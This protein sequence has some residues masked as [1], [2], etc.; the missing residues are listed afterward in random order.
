MADDPDLTTPPPK[1]LRNQ[2]QK[3]KAFN[4]VQERK[5]SLP[6]GHLFIDIDKKTRSQGS[7]DVLI[8]I[9]RE[10]ERSTSAK[11]GSSKAP[12]V[13]TFLSR[14]GSRGLEILDTLGSG[15]T[16]L[17]NHRG[18]VSSASRWNKVSELAF[19]VANTIVMGSN[20]MQ[21]LSQENIQIIE[22]EMLHS[23]RVQLLV[24]RDTKELLSIAAADKREEFEVFLRD[25][26]RFG[27][28]CKGVEWHSLDRF[29]VSYPKYGI[30]R[31]EAEIIMQELVNL[32]RHTSELYHESESLDKLEQFCWR[33]LEEVQSSYH[34]RKGESLMI[35][36]NEL[37]QQRKLV[38]NLKKKSLWSKS[39]DEVVEKL[40]E[41]V[42]FIR[43]EIAEAFENVTRSTTN[44]KESNKEPERLGI[45]GL[46]L[47]YANLITQI[48]CIATH[49][50]SLTLSMRDTLYNGLPATVKSDLRSSLRALDSSEVMTLPQIKAEMDKTLN[51]LVP[52][53]INTTKAHHGFGFVGEWANTG[54]TS[55][56]AIP[57][58]QF[59]SGRNEFGT[60]GSNNIIRLQT[61]YHADK[62]TMDQYILELLIWLNRLISLTGYKDDV[63]PTSKG[64]N[65]HPD[66]KL[67]SIQISSNDKNLLEEVAKQRMSVPGVSISQEQVLVKKKKGEAFAS[68]R[69][70]G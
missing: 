45:A 32:A 14:A 13:S 34:S 29:F 55:K 64:L 24:S 37:R 17:N 4:Y 23:E 48:N 59:E 40:V 44:G 51:W 65:L 5:Q 26:V 67:E 42:S 15:I 6:L 56:P 39:L 63:S 30:L 46:A 54:S 66:G 47:H 12:Y 57:A 58:H 70:M 62:L 9:S 60:N 3:I 18:F 20:L 35:L 7:K 69:S 36:Q 16:N 27:D 52:L 50:T 19:E 1:L 31:K 53:A 28:M 25:V 38:K 33:K 22:K 21:S 8:S 43:Q 41:V 2:L 61:F 11:V 49:P 68:S 10:L